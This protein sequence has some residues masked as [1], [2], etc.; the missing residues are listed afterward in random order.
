MIDDAGSAVAANGNA[1]LAALIEQ[2]LPGRM[3]AV[4]NHT[5]ELT[6]EV[7]VAGSSARREDA[8]RF[9]GTSIP[10]VHGRV[11]R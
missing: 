8:A 11:R 7:G 2:A 10:D 3:R 5:G 1:R 9:P 4:G 6:Y